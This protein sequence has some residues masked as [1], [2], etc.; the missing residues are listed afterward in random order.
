M[1]I[2]ELQQLHELAVAAAR[3]YPLKRDIY[4]LLE[5]DRG[6][7]FTGIAGP[8]GVGKT[9][10]LRQLA[11]THEHSFYVSVDTLGG[12]D[13][14]EL[15][16]RLQQN[17]SVSLLLLDE[18]HF[19]ADYH[20]QLKKIYDFLKIKVV[21]TS[22]VSLSLFARRPTHPTIARVSPLYPARIVA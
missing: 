9:V 22:S 17:Y 2:P 7:H 1:N 8:R 15:A 18:I 21:F 13:L 12:S 4:D 19:Q 3:E 16:Q 6:R 14:F 20:E 11:A 5:S 10:L